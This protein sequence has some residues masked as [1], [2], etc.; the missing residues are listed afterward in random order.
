[1]R[2]AGPRG[3]A[4]GLA[5]GALGRRSDGGRFCTAVAGQV[6]ADGAGVGVHLAS[7]GPPPP[8]ILRAGGHV[9][10]VPAHGPLL[11][12]TT[13]P[14]FPEATVELARG[15]LVLLYTDGAFELREARDGEA[16]LREALAASAG[17]SA[18]EVVERLERHALVM[19][20][21]E[22]RDDVALL[23]LRRV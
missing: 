22:P 15:E 10:E 7:A 1:M 21:G 12:V 20:G 8:L 13:R 23:A 4:L 18:A 14:A 9:E 19:S 3:A 11:G 16:A 2:R 5:Q 17:F 6:V